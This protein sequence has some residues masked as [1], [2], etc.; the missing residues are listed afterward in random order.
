[1]PNTLTVDGVDLLA[2]YGAYI[3]PRD[4]VES[5]PERTMTFYDLP[6][7]DGSVLGTTTSLR[8]VEITYDF[9]INEDA[10]SNLS[11]LRNFLLSRKGRLRIEDPND[12]DHFRRGVYLGPLKPNLPKEKDKA[13]GSIAFR[14]QPQRWLVS[15]ETVITYTT[16]GHKTI[17]N[18]TQVDG[19]PLIRAY[20]YG[21]FSINS[22][23]TVQIF[24][25]LYTDYPSLT[26]ID[27]DVETMNMY[28]GDTYLGKYVT[29]SQY[30]ATVYGM[31]ITKFAPGSNDFYIPSSEIS[32]LTKIE[33]TPRW[34]EV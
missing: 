4:D 6:G 34:W 15:G 31:D 1:M 24:S 16:S 12:T 27:I 8:D 22:A 26:Y 21:R 2:T 14:C 23:V 25:S 13:K 18:P 33:I 20:G 9:I 29:T 5:S 30:G 3:F 7:R 10:E 17:T 11:G 28:N 19:A 32:T